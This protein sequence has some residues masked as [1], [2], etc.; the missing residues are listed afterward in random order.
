MSTIVAFHED[1]L[2]SCKAQS[3]AQATQFKDLITI[4]VAELNYKWSLRC[5]LKL[6]C[7]KVKLQALFRDKRLL[8]RQPLFRKLWRKLWAREVPF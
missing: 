6:I 8:T 4:F 7:S 2:S 5:V 1:S 3:E